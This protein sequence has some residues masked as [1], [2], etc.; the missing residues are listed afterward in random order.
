MIEML[1]HYIRYYY[2][3]VFMSETSVKEVKQRNEKSIEFPKGSFCCQFFDREEIV[4]D[5]E[6]LVGKEKN[7]SGRFYNDGEVFNLEKLK[8]EHPDKETL[9]SNMK[10]NDWEKIILCNT[11][12]W[13]PFSEEDKIITQP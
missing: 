9:I 13:Q 6:P 4:K 3:G 2:P 7:H 11:G 5:N 8:K 1:K 10:C 12:N